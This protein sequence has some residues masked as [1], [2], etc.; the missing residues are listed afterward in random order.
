MFR[1]I[2]NCDYEFVA[3]WWD[4]VSENAK[5][6]TT[7]KQDCGFQGDIRGFK[8]QRRMRQR[9]LEVKINI[10]ANVFILRLFLLVL[11]VSCY[12]SALEMGWWERY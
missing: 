2:L 4:D 6:G 8:Q 7:A 3:P 1:R 5:V 12:Q 10:C 11:N 9:K